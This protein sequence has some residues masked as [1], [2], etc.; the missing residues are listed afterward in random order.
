MKKVGIKEALPFLLLAALAIAAIFVPALPNFDDGGKSYV[1]AD[2]SWIIV[3]TALWMSSTLVIRAVRSGRS[4]GD[5]R[6]GAHVAIIG[7]GLLSSE[8][9][10][11]SNWQS[12]RPS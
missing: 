7:F 9:M 6:S 8:V 2:I 11:N 10:P 4:V 3:A 1:P 5:T 12:K